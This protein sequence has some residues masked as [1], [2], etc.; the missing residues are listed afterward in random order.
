[1]K[2]HL[3]HT[4]CVN[5]MTNIVAKTRDAKIGKEAIIFMRSDEDEILLR[6]LHLQEKLQQH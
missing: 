3:N 1:M 4:S 6:V 2:S 5:Y